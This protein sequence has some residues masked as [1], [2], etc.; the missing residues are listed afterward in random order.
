MEKLLAGVL[1][2][3]TTA[4]A[5]PPALQ[6]SGTYHIDWDLTHQV[7]LVANATDVDTPISQLT[8]AWTEVERPAGAPAV[9]FSSASVKTP[10]VTL[11]QAG[12]Y[13]LRLTVSD[14]A[15]SSSGLVAINA[16][17]QVYSLEPAAF[18]FPSNGLSL[19]VNQAQILW[20]TR[21]NSAPSQ[22]ITVFENGTAVSNLT[23]VTASPTLRSTF[24]QPRAGAISRSLLSKIDN[25]AGGK[26]YHVEN[27]TTTGYSSAG[28][29]PSNG[30]QVEHLSI[31]SQ[32]L[33]LLYSPVFE[34][35]T[36]GGDLV[37]QAIDYSHRSQSYLPD[38][39]SYLVKVELATEEYPNYTG[40]QSQFDDL[41]AWE[42]KAPNGYK[43]GGVVAVNQWHDETATNETGLGIARALV[44]FFRI[45]LPYGVTVDTLQFSA[46]V[47]N[48]SDAILDSRVSFS[49]EEE[50]PFDVI[51]SE[52]DNLINYMAVL[53]PGSYWL[54]AGV[55]NPAFGD[56]GYTVNY[57]WG[58]SDAHNSAGNFYGAA[59]QAYVYF[60]HPPSDSS[61]V[62][63]TITMPGLYGLYV[64][65]T[66]PQ[67]PNLEGFHFF[68]MQMEK[69]VST[70]KV[71]GQV[72]P[73]DGFYPAGGVWSAALTLE[74]DP[75]WGPYLYTWTCVSSS[76]WTTGESIPASAYSLTTNATGAATFTTTVCGDYEFE[77]VTRD[78]NNP[79]VHLY[80]SKRFT[81]RMGHPEITQMNVGVT[82]ENVW[83][84]IDGVVYL[85]PGTYRFEAYVSDVEFGDLGIPVNY[86]WSFGGMG[87]NH[88]AT[89]QQ[90]DY[91]GNP[92]PN[93]AYVE[94]MVTMPNLYWLTGMASSPNLPGLEGGFGF[95]IYV[96]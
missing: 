8:Y 92:D 62:R 23:D 68:D 40:E 82:Q 4:L 53:K 58:V 74:S 11:G 44:G 66:C 79:Y 29:F 54:D 85:A 89:W 67:V 91:N 36:S 96:E 41:L 60:Y 33:S 47:Q 86:T 83:E 13:V 57:G 48:Q 42:M 90:Q 69:I 94:I 87:S 52:G 20:V 63:V 9:V 6:M 24:A 39:T 80:Q 93:G 88:G 27:I 21:N 45:T 19:P 10:T 38:A 32:E 31:A 50:N 15:Q 14:G 7:S 2:S 12:N 35:V 75:D 30:L 56:L 46:K 28:T 76:S 55:L 77:V 95:D 16:L 49:I 34:V 71:N 43:V 81:V 25:P 73:E 51:V 78:V 3:A 59:A 84:P 65:A 70:I 1:L 61:R 18:V 17:G 37:S 5:L 72:V 26:V 64:R 22:Q